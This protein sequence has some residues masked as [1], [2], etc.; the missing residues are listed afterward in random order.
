MMADVFLSD[1]IEGIDAM[2]N[3]RTQFKY[4]PIPILLESKNEAV[5]FFARRDLLGEDAGPVEKIWELPEARKILKGQQQDGSWA[6]KGKAEG[7]GVKY[8]LAETWRQLRYLIDQYQMDRSHPAIQRAAEYLFSCQ[9]GEGDIRGI[10]ANQYAPYYTGAILYLLIKAGYTDDPRVEK[11]IRW[12]LR[13]RQDDGGW[14][15]GSPGMAHRTWKE[16][17]ILTSEWNDEPER[18]FDKTL[19]FSAAGTGMAIR[20]LAVHPVYWRSE[21]AVK[22]ANLLKSKFFKKDNWSWYEHP[23][24]WVRFQFPYWWNHLIS[25]LDMISRIGLPRED[26][27]IRNALDWLIDH[28]KADGL[29]KV[30]YSTIHKN[31]DDSKTTEERLWITLCICRIFKRLME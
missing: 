15:I 7:P 14:M 22:A 20:A 11:G 2:D 21:E 1:Y 10:L 5:I 12:L 25:A 3:W 28:Q 17:L 29:W 27:D 6:P 19:P 30:S 31:P 4:D 9:S 8:A 13:M 26:A 16:V 18:D 23:D 24:N